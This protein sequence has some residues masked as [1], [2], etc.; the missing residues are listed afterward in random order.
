MSLAERVPGHTPRPAGRLL[1][2]DE[3]PALRLKPWAVWPLLTL[4]VIQVGYVAAWFATKFDGI[5]P[6]Q[7]VDF[8]IFHLVGRLYWQG[9][10]A[11]AY[12]MQALLDYQRELIGGVSFMPWTYPPPFDLVVA[13]L[14]LLPAW[15][16]YLVFTL[17][18][19]G[20]YLLVL[21]AV[22]REH[23]AGVVVCLLPVLFV[24]SFGGQNGFLTGSL[25]GSFALLSL[26]GSRL[27]GVPLGLMII[28]PH[29][30]L[31]VGFYL[32]VSRRWADLGVAVATAVAAALLSTLLLGPDIW[33]AFLHGM[34]ESKSYLAAGLYPL[35]RMTSV[36]AGLWT[37]GVSPD[38]A[39]WAHL[40]VTLSALAAMW[41]ITRRDARSGRA[42]A[43][44]LIATQLVSPY[45][46]DYD[47]PT[48]GVALA[49]ALRATPA[50]SSR[51]LF[52]P[53]LALVIFGGLY[54][55]MSTAQADNGGLVTAYL[56]QNGRPYGL[57]P[58]ALVAAASL[59]LG[60][61]WQAERPGRASRIEVG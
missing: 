23:L 54:P 27:A 16:A 33:G 1:R 28:K 32:L 12:R 42:L 30:A 49:L 22:A 41:V 2:G 11:E 36:Y 57:A 13:A 20:I 35:Q 18:T 29:L 7:L 17:G 38:V 9:D 52:L 5:E 43:A 39:L 47:L 61:M 4:M 19:L 53:V 58:F 14:A 21:R 10:L 25:L 59:L 6:V 26:K 48:L 45:S 55:L 56:V 40:A 24:T 46:Y 44:A 50:L 37:L 8:D 34:A 60:A 31:G 51:L 3:P 15:L